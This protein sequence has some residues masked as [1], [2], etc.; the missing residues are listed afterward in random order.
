[1]GRNSEKKHV[2]FKI[3]GEIV[4]KEIE[5][6]TWEKLDYLNEIKNTFQL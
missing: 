6:F 4:S 5:T 1:M 3:N 2:K